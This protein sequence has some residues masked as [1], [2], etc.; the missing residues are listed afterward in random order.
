MCVCVC[1]CVWAARVPTHLPDVSKHVTRQRPLQETL[2]AAD[3]PVHVH[4]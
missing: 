1:V 3:P 2:Q 4:T